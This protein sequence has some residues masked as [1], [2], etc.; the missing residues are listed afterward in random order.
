M[1]V[2]LS[3]VWITDSVGGWHPDQVLVPALQLGLAACVVVVISLL[4]SVVLSATANGIAVF[5]VFGGGLVAG[6]IG[7]IGD[8]LNNDT[9]RSISDAAAWVL[10]FEALYQDALDRLTRDT[11]GFARFF[12]QLGPFGGARDGGRAIVPWALAYIAI[13]GAHAAR[14]FGRRD[15]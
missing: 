3:A 13:A 10:P 5:M 1:A 2:F 15:L 7:Q 9:L 8:G 14:H 11:S 6:L 4:G 12:V